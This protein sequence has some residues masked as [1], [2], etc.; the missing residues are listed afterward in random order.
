MLY[1]KERQTNSRESLIPNKM[2]PGQKSRNTQN[3]SIALMSPIFN[4]HLEAFRLFPRIF[5]LSDAL[6][7]SLFPQRGDDDVLMRIS[8]SALV[9]LH[10]RLVRHVVGQG[11]DVGRRRRRRLHPLQS[12]FLGQNRAREKVDGVA[13]AADLVD[14]RVGHALAEP[15]HALVEEDELDSVVGEFQRSDGGGGCG[16]WW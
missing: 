5:G 9:Q 3:I 6:I 8:V 13:D 14:E 12:F 15:F 11:V 1:C 16:G 2:I 4:G 7:F 10:F